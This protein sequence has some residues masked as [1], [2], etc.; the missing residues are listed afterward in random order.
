MGSEKDY[1]IISVNAD[2]EEEVIIQA[3]A[4]PAGTD[5]GEFA[6]ADEAFGDAADTA[7]PANEAEEGAP[8]ADEA[9]DAS[10]KPEDAYR[11]TTLEDLKRS[12][13]MPKAQKVVMAAAVAGIIIFVLYYLFLR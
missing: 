4:V 6:R 1:S 5:A 7:H 8:S 2:D 11:E 3:G 10:S 9:P 12:E 13:P